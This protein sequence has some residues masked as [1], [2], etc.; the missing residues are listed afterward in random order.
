[1][2][3]R[4]LTLFA[5]IAVVCLVAG[6]M[7][8]RSSNEAA[9][10][11][12]GLSHGDEP[13]GAS[14][15]KA[16]E[17]QQPPPAPEPVFRYGGLQD[18]FDEIDKAIEGMDGKGVLAQLSTLRMWG[19]STAGSGADHWIWLT[20]MD[21]AALE[22]FGITR[23]DLSQEFLEDPE[24][25]KYALTEPGL[26]PVFRRFA[27]EILRYA[28]TEVRRS[29]LESLDFAGEKDVKVLTPVWKAAARF[30][31]PI[32]VDRFARMANRPDLYNNY[33]QSV[34]F[35]I[36]ETPGE[37]SRRALDAMHATEKGPLLRVLQVLEQIYAPPATGVLITNGMKPT[38]ERIGL[39]D[40]ILEYNGIAVR[41]RDDIAAADAY[42]SPGDVVTVKVLRDGVEEELQVTVTDSA[43]GHLHFDARP[44]VKP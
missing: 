32:F 35:A 15:P 26:N 39:A 36:A 24:L 41:T 25:I 27:A 2:T 21:D 3:A 16:P 7:V 11:N 14:R 13:I 29:I 17:P 44:I 33:R 40:I 9:E 12:E 4:T 28:P 31:D 1:M 20:S 34:A 22:E 43:P 5:A 10:L 18:I 42:S 30:K 6:Y 38:A 23:L 8:G 37:E 19:V